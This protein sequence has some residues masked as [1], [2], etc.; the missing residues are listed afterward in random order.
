MSRSC[1]SFPSRISLAVLRGGGKQTSLLRPRPVSKQVATQA[2][3]TRQAQTANGADLFGCHRL[4]PP[5]RRGRS[6]RWRNRRNSVAASLKSCVEG[7]AHGSSVRR[8]ASWS[9]WQRIFLIQHGTNSGCSIISEVHTCLRT[10]RSHPETVEN[11]CL[12]V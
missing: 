5:W 7:T 4:R 6:V 12:L 11:S 2:G 9:H 10:S 8:G 1:P 3:A